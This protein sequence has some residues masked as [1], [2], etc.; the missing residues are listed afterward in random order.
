MRIFRVR[1]LLLTAYGLCTEEIRKAFHKLVPNESGNMKIAIISTSQPK[2]K[3]KHSQ[4]IS[5]KNT[6]HEMGYRNVEFIDI[7]FEEKD[8]L[9][10][11][12]VIFLNGGH[13]FYL[14]YH[15]KKSG[16]DKILNEM[17]DSG[18]VVVGLSAGSIALGP[19]NTMCNYIYPEDNIFK[20]TDL[21]ALNAVNI[22]IYPHFKEHCGVNPIIENKVSEFES[23]Y[24]FEVTRL[25]NNQAILVIDDKLEKIG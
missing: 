9:N 12:D 11:F 4:M 2:L 1:R 7:E 15:L 14:L 13:P 10:E 23:K 25:N 20:V 22:R 18:K 24:N 21:S 5:V 6:F 19:D 3:E 16:A 8:K 17:I